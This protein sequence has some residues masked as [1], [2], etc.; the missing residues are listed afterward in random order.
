[1]SLPLSNPMDGEAVHTVGYS[2]QGREELD[3]TERLHFTSLS[4]YR[5]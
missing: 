5:V 3:T 4:L 2:P 1:M